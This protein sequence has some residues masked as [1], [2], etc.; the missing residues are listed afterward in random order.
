[1]RRVS[2]GLCI[3]FV[4]ICGACNSDTKP[5]PDTKTTTKDNPPTQITLA[6]KS[7]LCNPHCEEM[8]YSLKKDPNSK[9]PVQLSPSEEGSLKSAMTKTSVPA[10]KQT[11]HIHADAVSGKLVF[12]PDNPTDPTRDS[13][14]SNND[15]VLHNPNAANSSP[16]T[17]VAT[18]AALKLMKAKASSK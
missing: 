15:I 14:P 13:H 8:A 6:D 2:L 9:M 18:P 7:Q 12:T 1:M 11:A 3:A 4:M 17:V 16:V 10:G 5:I